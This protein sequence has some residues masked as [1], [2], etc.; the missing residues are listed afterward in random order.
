M[1]FADNLESPYIIK[2]ITFPYLTLRS[3]GTIAAK[4]K[5]LLE[6]NQA[7]KIKEEQLTPDQRVKYLAQA[8]I[9]D[10]CL[11]HIQDWAYTLVGSFTIATQSLVQSGKSA[12][13]AEKILDTI[14]SLDQVRDAA[15]ETIRHPFRPS[16]RARL[17]L[18]A[19][20]KVEVKVDTEQE[21]AEKKQ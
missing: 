2:D 11:E 9:L 12:E 16:I 14:A 18:E 5:K 3:I 6:L 1:S 20:E 8:N 10:P 7:E 19:K 4:Y 21:D 15:M 13:E 17:E